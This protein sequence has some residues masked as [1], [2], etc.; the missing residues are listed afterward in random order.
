MLPVQQQ[1]QQEEEVQQQAQQEEEVQQQAQQEVQQEGSGEAVALA[2]PGAAA[3]LPSTGLTS[4]ADSSAELSFRLPAEPQQ[5]AQQSQQL[6]PLQPQQLIDLMRVGT[7]DVSTDEEIELPARQRRCSEKQSGAGSWLSRMRASASTA[8]PADNSSMQ[9]QAVVGDTLHLLSAQQPVAGQAEPAEQ[10]AQPTVF[11][12]TLPSPAASSQMPLL[13]LSPTSTQ[14][15]PPLLQQQQQQEEQLQAGLIITEASASLQLHQAGDLA[16]AGS[17]HEQASTAEAISIAAAAST[18]DIR[19]GT[20]AAV[21]AW[22]NLFGSNK[23][24]KGK[25][26]AAGAAGAAGAGAAAAAA[27][28]AAAGP[29][30]GAPAAGAP[31]AGAPAAGA[32]AAERRQGRGKWLGSRKGRKQSQD[33]DGAGSSS[34]AQASA[35]AALQQEQQQQQARHTSPLE[36]GAAKPARQRAT[37][38]GGTPSPQPSMPT[39]RSSAD[40]AGTNHASSTPQQAQQQRSSLDGPSSTGRQQRVRRA[41]PWAS[42]SAAG[43]ATGEAAEGGCAA[44]ASS[45]SADPIN[46]WREAHASRPLDVVSGEGLRDMQ[47]AVPEGCGAVWPLYRCSWDVCRHDVCTLIRACAC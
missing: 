34:G 35:S 22:K 27:G 7:G 45:S 17:A 26:A 18:A 1:A 5:Q 43:A 31:A 37:T 3:E 6:Q 14:P 44:G 42:P 30:A 19:Q 9:A 38:S 24:G 8:A 12:V 32:A 25:A 46:F 33:A 4:V 10:A 11:P 39:R 29:A 2:E 13:V 40:D 36:Q 47:G 20:A 28:P 15:L 21:P 16:A 23:A 41:W